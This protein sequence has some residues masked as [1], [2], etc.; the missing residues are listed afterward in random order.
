MPEEKRVGTGRK[1][2]TSQRPK[3]I[4]L[5]QESRYQKELVMEITLWG[6]VSTFVA[7]V[8]IEPCP[9]PIETSG[10]NSD[11]PYVRDAV[12][13]HHL[14]NLS[15]SAENFRLI[16]AKVLVGGMRLSLGPVSF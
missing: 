7:Y 11:S 5:L 2:C 12:R 14:I 9:V 16:D 1:N 8:V 4:H 6:C 10:S 3:G 15:E 13:T